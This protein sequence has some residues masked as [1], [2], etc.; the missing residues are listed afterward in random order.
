M[1][2]RIAGLLAA[3]FMIAGA[4]PPAAAQDLK[5]RKIGVVLM[6][7]KWGAPDD[8][9]LY[10]LSH[11][12]GAAG[13]VLE[14]P[15]MPWS[16]HRNYDAGYDDALKEIDQAVA[17]LK[18]KGAQRIVVGGHSFGAN[19]A[20][21]YGATRDGVAGLLAL[22]PGHVPDL[23]R[24]RGLMAPDVARARTGRRRQGDRAVRVHRPQS[25]APGR[26]ARDREYFSQLFR[27]RRPGRDDADGGATQIGNGAVVGDRRAGFPVRERQGGDLRPRD[28]ASE[29]PLRSRPGRAHGNAERRHRD[30]A[31]V[32]E[33]AHRL[34]KNH[35][36]SNY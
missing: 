33:G 20:L 19:A 13:V 11:A 3:L 21:A 5:E 23:S 31:R 35:L 30:R 32:A 6:H 26:K 16:R 8:R 29:K 36:D 17:K 12:L 34:I 2:R 24:F 27:S 15:T 9:G 14:T 25:G 4:V 7:G 22:A 18:A 10:K 28:R 1:H